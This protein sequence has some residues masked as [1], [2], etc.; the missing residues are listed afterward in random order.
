MCFTAQ[1]LDIISW[2]VVQMKHIMEGQL[3]VH[4]NASI[5]LLQHGT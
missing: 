5:F 4:P 3:P 1:L 2:R